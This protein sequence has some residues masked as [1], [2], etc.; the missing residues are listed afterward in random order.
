MK[1]VLSLLALLLLVMTGVAQAQLASDDSTA[2]ALA[3]LLQQ[4]KDRFAADR[5]V[6]GLVS[7]YAERQIGIPMD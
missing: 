3:G 2:S 7:F 5:D 1:R 6:E 4:G